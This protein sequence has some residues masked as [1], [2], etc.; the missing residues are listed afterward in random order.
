MY[1]TKS[2]HVAK[3]QNTHDNDFARG[4]AM[5]FTFCNKTPPKSLPK[6]KFDDRAQRDHYEEQQELLIKSF[7]AVGM[8]VL[9]FIRSNC[10]KIKATVKIFHSL[11]WK[12]VDDIQNALRIGIMDI[13]V[14]AS[15]KNGGVVAGWKGKQGI[16]TWTKIFIHQICILQSV[17][18]LDNGQHGR[19]KVKFTPLAYEIMEH[20]LEVGAEIWYH[21]HD[22]CITEG[23]LKAIRDADD[24]DEGTE[25]GQ[26]WKSIW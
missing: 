22:F 26:V 10:M 16:S 12:D 6:V 13:N 11:L 1:L 19:T 3:S 23:F 4:I 8:G 9:R 21:Y 25:E 18:G 20:M 17:Y 15:G 7:N 5:A 24:V 14:K 2:E